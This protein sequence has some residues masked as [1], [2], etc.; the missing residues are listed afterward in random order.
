MEE[1]QLILE[2]IIV[3]IGFYLAFFKSYFQEKGKNLATKEDV[4][5]ITELVEKVKNQIHYNTQSKLSLKTE[6]RTVLVNYYENYNYW[7]NTVLNIYFGGIIEENKEKLKEFESRLKDAKFK[8]DIAEGKKEVFVN[9]NEIDEHLNQLKIKTLEL[10]HIVEEKIN[11]LEYL[12]FEIENMRKTTPI[13]NQLEEFKKLLAKKKI[14]L[15]SL[16]EQRLEKYKEI[17]PMDKKF[18]VLVFNHLQSIINEE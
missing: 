3:I 8:Y 10:Q 13:E 12:F 2:I 9:N 1:V 15:K 16:N 14:I 18:Q 5:E 4:E 6:E 7:L 17:A 11:E